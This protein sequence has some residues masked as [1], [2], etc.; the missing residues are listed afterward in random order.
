M[1]SSELFDAITELPEYY[2]TCTEIALFDTHMEEISALLEENICVIEY[3]GS[4]TKKI[5]RLLDVLNPEA[6]VPVDI[7]GEHLLSNAQAL[8]DD[9]PEPKFFQSALTSPKV[10]NY[11][12]R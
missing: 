12:R 7:A 3:D 10:V 11:L 9:F 2:V 6:Y 8:L 5:R 4:S 1:R